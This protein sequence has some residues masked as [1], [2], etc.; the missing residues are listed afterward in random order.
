VGPGGQRTGQHQVQVGPGAWHRVQAARAEAARRAVVLAR[1]FLQSERQ[2]NGRV[3]ENQSYG[4]N[5]YIHQLGRYVHRLTD[6]YTATYIRRLTDDHTGPIFVSF[7]YLGRLRYRGIYMCYI[8]R[9]R[10]IWKHQGTYAV[11]L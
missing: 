11:F 7:K 3:R 8:P 2:R 10:G 4:M 9:Y 5:P 1:I 6:E